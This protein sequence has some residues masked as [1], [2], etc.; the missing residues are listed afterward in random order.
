MCVH[1]VPAQCLLGPEDVTDPLKQNLRMV[2][3]HHWGQWKLYHGPPLEV[4]MLETTVPSLQPHTTFFK[5]KKLGI[6]ES[7]RWI[8]IS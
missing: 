6:L 4:Q 5:K 3:T 7:G 1:R 8:P 2:V